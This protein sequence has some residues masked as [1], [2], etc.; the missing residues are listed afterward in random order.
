MYS[1]EVTEFFSSRG[2][3]SLDADADADDGRVYVTLES[4]DRVSFGFGLERPIWWELLLLAGFENSFSVFDA[5]E[6]RSSSDGRIDTTKDSAERLT[7]SFGW[8]LRREFDRF[9]L[10]GAMSTNLEVDRLFFELDISLR[11]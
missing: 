5:E 1:S 9:F 6:R 2:P 7:Q 11:F 3:T 10:T 4:L 8:G